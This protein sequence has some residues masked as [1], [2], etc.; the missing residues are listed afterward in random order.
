MMVTYQLIIIYSHSST[1]IATANLINSFFSFQLLLGPSVAFC[2]WSNW[3]HLVGDHP[4]FFMIT[5]GLPFPNWV[6]CLCIFES[7]ESYAKYFSI[8]NIKSVKEQAKHFWEAR[9]FF[10]CFKFR[11]SVNKNLLQESIQII[12]LDK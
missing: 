9:R 1:S 12:F 4:S 6:A 11:P 8:H 10:L 3:E 2:D 7:P 5:E